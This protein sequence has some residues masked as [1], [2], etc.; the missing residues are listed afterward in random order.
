MA[1][2]LETIHGPQDIKSLTA[3]QLNQ[4]A[5]EM[6]ELITVSVSRTGGHLA[7]IM[8]LILPKTACC[9]MWGINV[10]PTRF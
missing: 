7:S 6:R 9:G 10:M 8:S 1:K 5:D 2:L 3:E 4:L